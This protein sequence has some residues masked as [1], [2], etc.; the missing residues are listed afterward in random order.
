MLTKRGKPFSG[1]E[2]S[3]PMFMRENTVP[4]V[5]HAVS[6]IAD[7]RVDGEAVMRRPRVKPEH[8]PHRLSGGRIWIGG[9]SYGIASE[10]NDPDGYVW[11]LLQNMDGTRDVADIV[12][13]TVRSHPGQSPSLVRAAISQLAGTGYLEDADA[14]DPG[15]LSDRDKER[16]D[17]ARGYYRWLDLTPRASTWDPQVKLARARVTVVGVGGTGGVAALALAAAGVGRLHCVDPDVVELSNLS[18]QVLYTEDDIGVAKV[19]AAVARLGRLN[20]DISVSGE[21]LRV[22]SAEDVLPLAR[23]CDVLLLSADKPPDVRVW[24][25]RACLAAGRPWVD[26]G[27]H[28]PLVQVAVYIPGRGGCWECL[29]DAAQ[30]QQIADGASTTDSPGRAGAVAS[31]VGAVPAGISGYLAAH[32]VIAL[33]TGVPPVE[34]GVIQ[35]INMAALDTPFTYR[36]RPDHPCQ[37][38]GAPAR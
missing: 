37:A 18:R 22:G 20:S 29:H 8:L 16:Y 33:V 17:R 13:R 23:D 1:S 36:E 30:E 34:P 15:E 2:M 28:G 7:E 32:Q 25:N 11:T 4:E 31:A 21:K 19:D 24:T 27:Y 9:V 6:G 10:I 26:A 12:E 5:T 38:C 14:P 35:G 3:Q